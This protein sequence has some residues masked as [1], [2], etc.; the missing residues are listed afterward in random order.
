MT[1]PLND[2]S[3][4]N[5]LDF[6]NSAISLY[7]SHTFIPLSL[8]SHCSPPHEIP[9]P[10]LY[11]SFDFLPGPVIA[12]ISYEVVLPTTLILLKKTKESGVACPEF[13]WSNSSKVRL[14]TVCGKHRA[15]GMGD[16]GA[17]PRSRCKFRQITSPGPHFLIYK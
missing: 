2:L 9:P 7:Y 4:A 1:S 5:P 14:S 3:P 13:I 8:Y 15:V 17:S 12:F 10:L 16:R 11:Q 6:Y